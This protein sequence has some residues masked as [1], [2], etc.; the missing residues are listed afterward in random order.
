VTQVN[1]P[2]RSKPGISKRELIVRVN[3]NV[4]DRGGRTILARTSTAVVAVQTAA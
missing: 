4:V 1:G 3:F 2:S